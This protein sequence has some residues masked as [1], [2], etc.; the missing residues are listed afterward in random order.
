MPSGL[1]SEP[2]RRFQSLLIE[3]RKQAGLTQSQVSE[4][5]Y[6]PQSFVA[7]YEKGE[8]RLDVL[9]FLEVAEAI[10]FEPEGFIRE[11]RR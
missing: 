3:R 7:K 9:E 10:G 6:K 4:K 5:L 2:Y 1:H 8:R 11:L